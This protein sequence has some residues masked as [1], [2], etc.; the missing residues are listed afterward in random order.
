[1]PAELGRRRE[2]EPVAPPIRSLPLCL[3][4]HEASLLCFEWLR[5]EEEPIA[6][7]IRSSPLRLFARP[8]GLMKE[9][10]QHWVTKQ[11]MRAIGIGMGYRLGLV[12]FMKRNLFQI[13]VRVSINGWRQ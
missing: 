1:L 2:E 11:V 7:S 5:R 8:R 13:C 10:N 6:P 3:F 12:F 9:K 4:A